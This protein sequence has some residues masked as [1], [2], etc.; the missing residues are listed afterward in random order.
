M[1]KERINRI[2]SSRVFYIV[3]AIVMALALWIYLKYEENPD[4]DKTVNSINVVFTSENMLYEKNLKITDISVQTLD[5]TFT[6]KRSSILQLENT[7]TVALVDLSSITE[8]GVH[9]LKYEFSY[10]EDV[11][12]KLVAV[13]KTSAPFITIVVEGLVEKTVPVVGRLASDVA[14]ADGFQAE[15]IVCT[16]ETVTVYGSQAEVDMISYAAVIIESDEDISRTVVREIP[17]TLM[18]D[19][20]AVLEFPSVE[21]EPEVVTAT[22]TVKMVKT[23][24]LVVNIEHGLSTNSS[25]TVVTITPE[26]IMLTGDVDILTGIDSIEIG[27]INMNSAAF[28]RTTSLTMPITVPNNIENLS[29]ISDVAVSIKVDGISTDMLSTKNI[30]IANKPDGYDVSIITESLVVTLRGTEANLDAVKPED[31]IVTADLSDIENTGNISV[32]ATVSIGGGLMGVDAI[33][34]YKITIVVSKTS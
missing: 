12:S 29:G 16:P 3:F 23:V 2:F 25:N 27:T 4:I 10:P 24:P 28:N 5:V 8:A 7:N 17:I 31:I 26:T 6:G 22:M 11:S 33:G 14:V 1:L 20:G 19:D 15:P 18:S 21:V 13:T 30:Q 32:K 9:E 34:D